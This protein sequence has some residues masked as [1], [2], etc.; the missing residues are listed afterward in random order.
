MDA[1]LESRE[2]L[3]AAVLAQRGE[4]LLLLAVRRF[5]GELAG[6]GERRSPEDVGRREVLG[7]EHGPLPHDEGVLHHV[8]QLA[9]VARIIVGQE[10]PKGLGSDLAHGP[11][12]PPAEALQ[13]TLDQ[14]RNVLLALGQGRYVDGDDSQPVVE[15]LPE[16]AFPHQALDVAARR[17]DHAHLGAG[18]PAAL[19]RLEGLL[20]EDV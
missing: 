14:Q 18:L 15:I 2:C 3:V 13:S 12:A 4:Q 11:V 10:D 17:G 19:G 5:P 8:L 7:L 16:P 9:H 6:R 20:L 1:E